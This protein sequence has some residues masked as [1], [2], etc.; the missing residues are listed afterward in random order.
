MRKIN[1][2]SSVVLAA[3][4][5][6]SAGVSVQAFASNHSSASTPTTHAATSSSMSS[7]S[8]ADTSSSMTTPSTS[9]SMTTPTSTASTGMSTSTMSMEKCYGI[10][11][12]GMN[13]CDANDSSCSAAS[14]MDGDVNYYVNL[15]AGVCAKLVNGSLVAG[16]GATPTTTPT[17]SSSSTTPVTT[18]AVT[19]V[20]SSQSSSTED[21][22]QVDA[23]TTPA[24]KTAANVKA[25][26]EAVYP[27]AE[28]VQTTET[29]VVR[30][31]GMNAGRHYHYHYH[32][33]IYHKNPP[34]SRNGGHYHYHYHYSHHRG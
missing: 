22:T 17:S 19:G 3:V 13:D 23:V 34:V 7:T 30:N 26:T 16:Q 32:Y 29:V 33:H 9:S 5:L 27:E 18:P 10:A 14:T 1:R 24:G 28:M 8:G 31:K 21:E 11:K 25:T 15:P 6:A 20:T 12:T 4:L 2:K